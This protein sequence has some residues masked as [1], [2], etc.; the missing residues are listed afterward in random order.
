[1]RGTVTFIARNGAF[2]F[3]RPDGSRDDLYWH[4]SA[5]ADDDDAERIEVFDRVEF[6]T[7][8][9]ARKGGKLMAVGVRLI[10]QGEMTC[11]PES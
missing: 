1:M 10:R 8:P 3:L 4:E 7:A 11:R 6:E 5:I 2:G 9:N